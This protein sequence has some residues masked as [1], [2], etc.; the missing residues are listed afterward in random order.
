MTPA[1]EIHGLSK[2]YRSKGRTQTAVKSLDLTVPAGQVLAFLGPNGAGKT[3]TIKMICGLIT[4]TSGQICLNGFDVARQPRQAR[5]QI[6]AVLEGTRNIYWRIPTLENVLYFGRLRGLHG[7]ALHERAERLLRELNLWDRRSDEPRHFSRGMQQKL[8]IACA[9]VTDPPIVLL[10][11]PTLGLDVQAAKTVEEWVEK[12]AHEQGKTVVITTHQLDM[13][14]KI[15]DRVAII[16]KGELIADQP[17][18]ELLSAPQK[19]YYEIKVE[20]HYDRAQLHCPE[21]FTVALENG[22]TVITGP[23]PHPDMLYGL[24]YSFRAQSLP[25]LSVARVEPNLEEV[26]IELCGFEVSIQ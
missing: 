25:L 14:Q 23:V 13:A 1:I 18:R 15:S 2:I 12:L 24:L 20:G 7:K 21:A 17:T 16:N 6:S 3:T 8:A 9:L 11:E 26:F 19:E 4:P 10:D 22:H 5:R